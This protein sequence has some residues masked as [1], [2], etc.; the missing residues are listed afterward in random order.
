MEKTKQ[1]FTHISSQGELTVALKERDVAP[2][3]PHEVLVKIEAAPINPSDMWPM[4]GPADLREGVFHEAENKLTAPVASSMLKRIGSRIDQELPIGNEGAGTVVA[5]GDSPQAQALMGKTVGVLSGATY[6]EFCTVPV[7]ACILHN[8]GTTAKQAASSFVNPLTALSM[9]ET[10]RREGHSALVHTAAA[11]SLGIML[12]KICLQ[13]GIDLVN[14]VRKPE[15]V[16]I[17]KKLGA[18][19][20]LNSTADSFKQDLY[21]AIE[22][23]GATLA[24][25]A[26]GGGNL[27]SDILTAMEA[28]GSKDAVG[29]NTYG[30][31]ENKQ[32]YIYGGLDFAPTVLNRAYGMT[33]N[34]GGW[35]LMRFLS[36]LE[37]KEVLALH[38]RVADEINTTFK[39]DFSNEISL[40]DA[41]KLNNVAGYYAKKTG[42]KYLI[43]PT[44]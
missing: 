11:S 15:Q 18:K 2:L 36:K 8:E 42:E 20:V 1:L 7:Q 10:M 4:F 25:D 44:L 39:L 38:K 30:S 5:A 14:I 32:V 35:L 40:K 24:F 34:I 13:E 3:K 41:L 28:V 37:I 16:T 23:T 19:H 17:L 26:I 22:E 12:N 29:F 6:S 27:V 43:N 31:A 21:K 9:V 33:W